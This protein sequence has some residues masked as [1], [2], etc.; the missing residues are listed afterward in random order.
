MIRLDESR[1]PAGYVAGAFFSTDPSCRRVFD[2]VCELPGDA[3]G[4]RLAR[5][6]PRRGLEGLDVTYERVDGADAAPVRFRRGAR[7]DAPDDDDDEGDERED[8]D[9]SGVARRQHVQH[10]ADG[11]APPDLIIE[12]TS[13]T[14]GGGDDGGEG[15]GRRAAD[16]RRVGRGELVCSCRHTTVIHKP[17]R[18]IASS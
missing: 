5:L 16:G 12:H 13:A 14:S 15:R 1:L 9:D 10:T 6:R 18:I 11:I 8:R 3:R 2:D 4:W 7:R 17:C